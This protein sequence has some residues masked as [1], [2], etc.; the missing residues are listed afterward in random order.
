MTDPNM[1]T[2]ELKTPNT[3]SI[4]DNL[5]QGDVSPMS[6]KSTEQIQ[7]ET[8]SELRTNP[9]NFIRNHYESVFKKT[10][11]KVFSTLALSIPSLLL[12]DI[13]HKKSKPIKAGINFLLIIPPGGA[14]SAIASTFKRLSY[15]PF[16]FESITDSKLYEELSRKEK[17]SLIVGDV[18]KIFSNKDLVKT[19]ENVLG[20]EQKLSRMTRNTS[21]EEKDIKAI[22]FLAG[23]PNSLTTVISDGMI[24]RMSVCLI[25]HNEQEH[26]E[27]GDYIGNGTFQ[28]YDGD[29]VEEMIAQYYKTLEMVQRGVH[30]NIP[31]IVGYK[32]KPE[33]T[34]ELTETWK[35]LVRATNR[36]TK[37]NFFRELHQGFRYLVA[38]AFLNIYNRE[39]TKDGKLVITQDDVD[40]A[41]Y[42]MKAE[43]MTKTRLLTCSRVV[44]DFKLKTVEDLTKYTQEVNA[45][46]NKSIGKESQDIIA[47]LLSGGM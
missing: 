45:Q 47:N 2:K 24:F 7:K 21:G 46:Y 37:F 5:S 14:K 42:L 41:K 28:E 22:A 36:Q 18:F 16:S 15:S 26:E 10:G 33:F 35:P 11:H 8:L 13:P 30:P 12:P 40:A 6:K 3:E 43:I 17:V 44:S 34:K 38:H 23:T 9:Y 27:I 4:L 1:F 29:E 39:V 19:M 25:F 31:K 20:D 32:V